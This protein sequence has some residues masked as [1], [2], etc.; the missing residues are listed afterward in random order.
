MK[1]FGRP[2]GMSSSAGCAAM[3]LMAA[4]LLLGACQSSRTAP[5]VQVAPP[6]ASAESQPGAPV[7]IID[8]NLAR[9]VPAP[10][11]PPPGD[12]ALPAEQLDDEAA[13]AMVSTQ[14]SGKRVALLLPLT[15]PAS[16]LGQPMLNAAQLALLD[17]ADDAFEIVVHDS[18]GTPE[19][20][21]EASR[22]AV[23]DG[24]GLI[25][26]P[27]LAAEV[28]A[29]STVARQAG[30]NIIAFTNDRLVAGN[31][32]F[33]MGFLPEA[34]VARVVAYATSKGLTRFAVLAPENPYG[35]EVVDGL[36]RAAT[37]RAAEVARVQYYNPR[38]QGI[39]G[40]VRGLAD[41]ESRKAQLDTQRR[42]LAGR[43]DEASK[44]ALARLDNLQTFG[45]LPYEALL[46]AEGGK[47]LQEI[48]ALLPYYDI[49]PADVRML[50]TMQWDTPTTGNEPAL[51]GGWYA[52][53]PPA[54]RT[55]FEKRYAEAFGEP[56][57]R[58]ATLAYDA[59]ALAA[60]FA[61]PTEGSSFGADL[62]TDPNGF[63]G[64]DG[65]FRFLPTGLNERGYAVLQ[66]EGRGSRVVEPPPEAF[67]VPIN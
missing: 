24:A 27:L 37:T 32:V 58:L 57:P 51:V 22:Q 13:S 11:Q 52:A 19:G 10:L 25:L 49:D 66:V 38:G 67:G 47:T 29:A 8:D 14:P 53:P 2:R 33:I 17:F 1:F 43:D 60:V 21:A 7:E 39:D 65:I 48:A 54:S 62:I 42:A 45:A 3:A 20:A 41:F 64:R 50:G 46:V 55:E 30:I 15:G 4:G 36:R 56:P 26:G 16:S 31:G 63:L 44:K 23:A 12:N 18:K 35:I 59:A 6:R 40:A 9:G 61:R 28:D 34:Q 5:P